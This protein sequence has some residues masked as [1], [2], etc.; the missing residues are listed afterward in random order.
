MKFNLKRID[1]IELFVV[2]NKELIF[3]LSMTIFRKIIF[4]P[5][6]CLVKT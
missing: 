3:K 2:I 5:K 4:R 1:F 6:L